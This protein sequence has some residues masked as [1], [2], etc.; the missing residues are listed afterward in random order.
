MAISPFSHDC[1]IAVEDA[2]GIR[3]ASHSERY[4]RVKNDP[5]LNKEMVKEAMSYGDIN[6]VTYCEKPI[7]KRTRQFM[8][9]QWGE[10]FS[11]DSVLS[12]L[13]KYGIPTKNIE[14]IRHHKAHALSARRASPYA[15]CCIV[16]IDAI[17]EWDTITIWKAIANSYEIVARAKYPHSLGLLY[18]AFTQRCGLKPNED[19]Y[20]MMGMAAYGKP[21]Y[22]MQIYD[23]FVDQEDPLFKLR[24]NCHRGIGSYLPNARPVDIAASIQMVTEWCIY[25]IMQVAKELTGEDSVIY[26][27]GVALNCVANSQIWNIFKNMWI[28]PNPGDAGVC[29]AG[30]VGGLQT[31]FQTFLGH[32][33]DRP[34][35]LD[36]ILNELLKGNIVGVANGR[37]EFGPRAF[38]NRS[39][40]ADPRI[41]G[42]KDRVNKIKRR[43]EFRPFAPAILGD[44]AKEYFD[45]PESFHKFYS[46]SPYM[47]YTFECKQP[48]LFPAIVHK[49][50]TSR[51]QTVSKHDNENFYELLKAFHYKTGC[52]MLLNTS[53]NIKGEP[54]VNTWAHAKD[55]ERKYNVKVY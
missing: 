27:G 21:R 45:M 47:Q 2:R 37:A 11:K 7:L 46:P 1:A 44:K 3:F 50:E 5:S 24:I 28:Y 9:R 26:T 38:G 8:A 34:F 4:S 41:M 31:S 51:I 18:S 14:F 54:L 48:K 17:G 55:F 42:M 15:N 35:E 25:K 30:R 20:I 13:K 29:L 49:D 36:N 19:E 53:L 6:Y 39:L 52:P 33:I 23:D 10:V 43:Q 12:E 16:C 40:L 22:A 32:N